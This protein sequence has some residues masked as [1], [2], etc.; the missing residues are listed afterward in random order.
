MGEQVGS[1][2]Y[3]PIVDQGYPGSTIFGKQGMD[4]NQFN[5]YMDN[6]T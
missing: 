3:T 5:K 1:I 2:A 6:F 4:L